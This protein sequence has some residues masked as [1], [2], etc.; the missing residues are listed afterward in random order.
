[1]TSFLERWAT[2]A[3]EPGSNSEQRSKGADIASS[4]QDVAGT[5]QVTTERVRHGIRRAIRKQ[6]NLVAATTKF[7]KR[8]NGVWARSKP[9]PCEFMPDFDGVW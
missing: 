2:G 1:M 3:D 7:G 9:A 5:G 8:G 4:E 6:A